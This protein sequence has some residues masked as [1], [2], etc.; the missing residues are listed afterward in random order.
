MQDRNALVDLGNLMKVMVPDAAKSAERAELLAQLGAYGDGMARHAN[1]PV[2]RPM[3]YPRYHRS[4][5]QPLHGGN[6][7][8][9]PL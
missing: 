8:D 2:S 6:S 5:A 9:L 1:R 3:E 7:A 4:R